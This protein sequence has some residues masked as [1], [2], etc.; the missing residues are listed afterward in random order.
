VPVPPHVHAASLAVFDLHDPSVAVLALVGDSLMDGDIDPGEKADRR[1]LFQNAVAEADVTVRF[2]GC[3]RHLDV[4]VAP[5]DFSEVT[6]F[7]VTGAV[8]E[9]VCAGGTS[10]GAVESGVMTLLLRRPGDGAVVRTA[11]VKI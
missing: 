1:L 10:L 5:A 8:G 9:R 3:H 6:L 11:W 4:D 2:A 7:R